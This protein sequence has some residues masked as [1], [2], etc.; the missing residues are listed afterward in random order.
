MDGW[1]RDGIDGIAIAIARQNDGLCNYSYMYVLNTYLYSGS[2]VHIVIS[3]YGILI[4]ILCQWLSLILCYIILYH[5]I[6]YHSISS[7]FP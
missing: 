1:R 3:I 2:F 5:V 4:L 7:R 6:V